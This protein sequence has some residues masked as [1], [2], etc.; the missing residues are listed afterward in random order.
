MS[1][2]D[3][4]FFQENLVNVNK[5]VLIILICAIAVPISFALGNILFI[6]YVPYSFC[7]AM[8]IYEIIAA[9][10]M[11][12]LNKYK[13]T[14]RIAQY[15]GVIAASAFVALMA[16]RGIIR[17]S[18]S[19]AF[20]TIISCL[21]YNRPLTIFTCI[22]D[23]FVSIGISYL[24][25]FTDYSVI[26]G[27]YTQ[28]VFMIQM[29]IG[30]TIEFLFLLYVSAALS[31]RTQKTMMR[32][33]H[34][35]EQSKNANTQL[36]EK[37][38][39]IIKINNEL[40]DT[41]Y[42]LNVTQYKIIQFVAQCLGSHDLF[43]G[44]HVIHTQKYV[45]MLCKELIFEKL[46]TNKLN[47]ETIKLY[48][49]AAFLHDIGKIHIPEGI[50]NKPGKFTDDD[51][52]IMKCH[53]EEGQ[54]LLQFLPV[55]EEGNFNVIASQM[56]YC[57]H[58]KWD[59][60]GY[61]RGLAGTD[62]PLAA[63]IMAAADVLDA[64]ISQRLY[65]NPMSIDEAMEVFRNSSG[66]HFEPCIAQAVINCRDEIEAIDAQFKE[67][68]AESNAEEVEWWNQYHKMIKQ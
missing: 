60:S 62:I 43:T 34:S 41:N 1:I 2:Y 63:R 8:L 38:A 27:V 31:R 47:K 49:M 55:I 30:L 45:E 67:E 35:I 3:D 52:K 23:Y 16:S 25:S 21:Y 46:Y 20:G 24:Q 61:P 4:E 53:P 42:N 17:L 36:Q 64:L 7:I 65:K 6:W 13:K 14:Q 18:I 44:R 66:T 37:N 5:T 56:A 26:N 39:Y 57:H 10:I 11:F 54:N 22:F 33:T 59:G 29:V 68:E 51:Y 15:F 50:L 58:E 9:L 12:F 19:Y 40:E 48:S 32:L 28:S